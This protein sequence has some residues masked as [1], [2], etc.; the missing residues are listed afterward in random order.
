MGPIT[1][2]SCVLTRAGVGP[3][4]NL[5]QFLLS[6]HWHE[7]WLSLQSGWGCDQGTD[8]H[9]QLR[10]HRLRSDSATM[11]PSIACC[12]SPVAGV[13]CGAG[14]AS[15]SA[16]CGSSCSHRLIAKSGSEDGHGSGSAWRVSRDIPAI[17]LL[18]GLSRKTAGLCLE[19]EAN[20]H[21]KKAINLGVA[22]WVSA[23]ISAS[24]C[25]IARA[26]A[27]VVAASVA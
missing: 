11:L 24:R 14:E 22:R 27:Q 4:L 12:F 8:Q 21:K 18:L 15:R 1:V 25:R 2:F 6:R 3:Q 5:P 26:C 9:K 13:G 17:A 20:L 19:A 23:L 10:T 7:H 16:G